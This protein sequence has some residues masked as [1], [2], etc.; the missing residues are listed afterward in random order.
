VCK[1]CGRS[2]DT[3]R[4]LLYWQFEWLKRFLLTWYHIVN[5]RACRRWL[6]KKYPVPVLTVDDVTRIL[7]AD[8][9][10]PWDILDHKDPFKFFPDGDN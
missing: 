5:R 6:A 8:S 9:N 10:R 1:K 7:I 4:H 3:T 2:S